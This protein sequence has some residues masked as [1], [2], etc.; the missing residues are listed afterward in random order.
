MERDKELQRFPSPDG[1]RW[2]ELRERPDGLFYFQEFYEVIVDNT[3]DE[4]T[5]DLAI[6]IAWVVE[7]GW[8]SGL[9]ERLA[10]AQRDLKEM[11]P[12]LRGNSN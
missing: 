1:K 4:T 5:D 7:Q 3:A 2:I 6:T 8:R 11:T 10:D 9:Y 12:W